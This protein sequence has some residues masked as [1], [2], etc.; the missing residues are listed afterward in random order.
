MFKLLRF[1]SVTSFVFIL[2]TAALLTMFY[3]Q[4][5]MHWIEHL[6]ESGNLTLAQ[7]VLNS[8]Q[9]EFD[10][11]LNK[12]AGANDHDVHWRR[13]LADLAGD[14]LRMTQNTS[15]DSVK[16]YNRN[17][18]VSFSTERDQ[19]GTRSAND[20][21]FLLASSGQIFST[22]TFRDALNRFRG[23]SKE[24]NLMHT[25][26]PIRNGPTEPILG[27]LEIHTDMN[28]LIQESD[29]NLLLILSGAVL[30]LALLYAALFFVVRHAK[31][32][33]EAQQ[34]TIQERTASLE[35][36]SRQLLKGEEFKNKKIA[37]D[38]HEGLAQTLSAIKVNVESS[39]NRRKTDNANTQPQESIVPVLQSAI[40]EV[41]TIATELW[42][43]SLDD[44]GLLPTI[45]WLCREF[46]NRHPEI[47]IQREISLPERMIPQPL[48]IVIYRIIESS[49]KNIVKYSNTDQIRFILN[50]ADNMIHLKIRDTPAEQSTVAA[51]GRLDPTADPHFRFAEVKERTKLSGGSFSTTL[52]YSGGVTLHAS[53]TCAGQPCT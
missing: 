32:I 50:L 28:H 5:T 1:Y 9:P 23:A 4:V 33:I 41:R 21:G 46:E 14:I 8:I 45:N 35:I 17:G 38:L 47:R 48:K 13:P 29:R 11:Y 53:W 26:I 36:L 43:S 42:P 31:N 52:E 15:V 49:F 27:V 37:I 39:N 19:I 16:I 25:Y 51:V 10:A 22:M 6:A 12:D 24:D 30:I 3:R 40:H 20:P 2:A 44:L 18:L 7:T 34:K